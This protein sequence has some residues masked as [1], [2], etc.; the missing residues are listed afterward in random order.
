MP[1][2]HVRITRHSDLS[3]DVVRIDYSLDELQ[4]RVLIPYRKGQPITIKGES[5][6][7]NDIKRI[8]INLTENDSNSVRQEVEEDERRSSISFAIPFEWKIAGWG[9]DV[10]D[11]FITDPPG[12]EANAVSTVPSEPRPSGDTK[13]VFVVH[14]RNSAAR[15]ALF[16]FLRSIGLRP[17]EWSV[18]VQATGKPTPYI[19]EILGA[20]FSRAHAVVVLFTPDDEVRLRKP[21]HGENEPPHEVELTGQARPN[22][23]FEAGMAMARSED[24]TVLVELGDLRPFSD[25][26][27]RHVVRL[28]GTPVRRQTL[29]KRLESAGCPV[30]LDGSDWLTAGDF[31]AVIAAL[32]KESAEPY[33]AVEQQKK[34]LSGDAKLL[35]IEAV[36]DHNGSIRKVY[37]FGGLILETN[38]K[39]FPEMGNTRSEAQWERAV[40]DLIGSGFIQDVD[41]KGKAFKVTHRGFQYADALVSC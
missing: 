22:V 30:D 38:D 21:L 8:T 16:S 2:Y 17:L 23:L 9:Q 13:E 32:S 12:S 4:Q 36:K 10:T 39:Q 1:F 31:D 11:E 35:L 14:G 5:V 19:G 41:G 28:D 6:P 18:A 24:R 15:N 29:A 20:A 34:D 7:T 25:I 33:H 37:V 26:G 40:R 3:N 27:G